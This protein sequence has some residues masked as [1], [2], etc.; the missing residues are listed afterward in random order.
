M[1]KRDLRDYQETCAIFAIFPKGVFLRRESFT[2][3]AGPWA[4]RRSL[5]GDPVGACRRAVV[6][7]VEAVP[8]AIPVERVADMVERRAGLRL[9]RIIAIIAFCCCVPCRPVLLWR[10]QS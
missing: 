8:I 5:T 2:A 6:E 1:N 10:C 7:V 4:T 3:R 9:Q